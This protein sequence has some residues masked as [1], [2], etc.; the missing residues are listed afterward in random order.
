MDERDVKRRAGE[1]M[2]FVRSL[3]YALFLLHFTGNYCQAEVIHLKNGQTVRASVVEENETG[4]TVQ[5][6]FGTM[7]FNREEILKI[8][9]GSELPEVTLSVAKVNSQDSQEDKGNVEIVKDYFDDGRLKYEWF[10]KG[11]Q[12]VREKAYYE[13][14]EL[15]YDSEYKGEAKHGLTKRYDENGQLAGVLNYK[16]G[17]LE[18]SGKLYY[19]SGRLMEEVNYKNDKHD[20]IIQYYF[21]TGKAGCRVL[22][23]KG[24]LVRF[25][26]E[27]CAKLPEY[28]GVTS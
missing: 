24:K 6:P 1:K 26:N 11:E 2:R 19:E 14:G 12:L 15:K 3:A 9:E 17:K 27:E 10:Y 7:T 20:G 5:F 8:E 18:G 21:E 22:Y 28:R 13:N 4:V 23:E 16:N 25:L